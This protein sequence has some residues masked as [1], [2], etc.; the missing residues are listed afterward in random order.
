M[1][2]NESLSNTEDNLNKSLADKIL[3]A[4]KDL[5]ALI[6]EDDPEIYEPME[7]Y[8]FFVMKCSE[9]FIQ[10]NIMHDNY[11]SAEFYNDRELNDLIINPNE[12]NK[13]YLGEYKKIEDEKEHL[14][15][16]QIEDTENKDTKYSYEKI[17]SKCFEGG[18]FK[19][20]EE[21]NEN[22]K[23]EDN[24]KLLNKVIEL[25]KT[26]NKKGINDLLDYSDFLLIFTS[27]IKY[28]AWTVRSTLTKQEIL[29]YYDPKNSLS[30]SIRFINSKNKFLL[31][32]SGVPSLPGNNSENQN[33]NYRHDIC[34][35][36]LA[37]TYGY[38]L[39]LKPFA[40]YYK[41]RK[42][43][44]PEGETDLKEYPD[45]KDSH[46]EE[47]QFVD[48]KFD[49]PL[50]FPP[51]I[52]Y[53]EKYDEAIFRRYTSD[54]SFTNDQNASKFRNMDKLRLITMVLDEI[55]KLNYLI[56]K[57]KKVEEVIYCRNYKAYQKWFPKKEGLI[58][59]FQQPK[60]ANLFNTEEHRSRM[61]FLRNYF[62]EEVCFYFVWLDY[63]CLF[64]IIPGIIGC[65]ISYLRN[66]DLLEIGKNVT[67][68]EEYIVIA[69]S[70]IL[71]VMEILFYKI[72]LSKEKFYAHMWGTDS[73]ESG[74]IKENEKF[75]ASEEE[76]F[77][78][79]LKIDT[80]N[81]YKTSF[82]RKASY[83]ILFLMISLVWILSYFLFMIK[84]LTAK[85]SFAVIAGPA[86]SIINA[87]M[88]KI[89]RAIYQK[90]ASWLTTSE[91]YK[92]EQEKEDALTFKYILFEFMNNYTSLFYIA[93]I[94]QFREGCLN[95]DCVDEIR[96]TLYFYFLTFFLYYFVEIGWPILEAKQN[97]RQANKDRFIPI[98]SKKEEEIKTQN[99]I[100]IKESN[101]NHQMEILKQ[102]P[103]YLINIPSITNMYGEYYDMIILFGH[104]CFFSCCAPLL[105]AIVFVYVYIARFIDY[106][107]FT[108]LQR[109]DFLY[110]AKGIR[111]YN[112][113]I[114]FFVFIGSVINV[115]IILVHD[116]ATNVIK[117]KE[118]IGNLGIFCICENIIALMVYAIDWPWLPLWFKNIKY[119]N[120]AYH[121]EIL[122]NKSEKKTKD[123]KE[124][125]KNK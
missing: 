90:I 9:S 66:Y 118:V 84:D 41:M 98:R 57:S 11:Y 35:E 75:E 17:L 54:D 114:L 89:F 122:R 97:A 61:N 80:D 92:T 15:S 43:K 45:L 36:H 42:D 123:S 52:K 31:I 32:F 2:L 82:K 5:S 106:F 99:E 71:S 109:I 95:N 74:Y 59:F 76:K 34:F 4:Y 55:L 27:L 119:I 48:F 70:L 62:C 77:I 3:S 110:G 51:Y 1:S 22:G 87:I 10:K 50:Y 37:Q 38:S 64:L 63:F 18:L 40:L 56:D 26:N 108:E 24:K 20:S 107:K 23:M 65:V 67:N 6:R 44:D 73:E 117:Q 19:G 102:S 103:S 101:S 124:S 116:K 86:I 125:K 112:K 91:N 111:R 83:I 100:Q 13:E 29:K 49:D 30:I 85:S 39:Q 7:P 47:K 33:D 88:I 81:S 16:E 14:L 46:I 104:V 94:K 69:Y 96:T 58:E 21:E 78:F 60:V 53:K 25:Y 105:A 68:W 113:C 79:G 28:Y 12:E 93:F 72:W 115:G 8:V 121:N 120:D